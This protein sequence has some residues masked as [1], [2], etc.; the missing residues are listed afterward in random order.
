MYLHKNYFNDKMTDSY[1]LIISQKAK[2]KKVKEGKIGWDS[3]PSNQIYQ[4]EEKGQ[5]QGQGERQ[6]KRERK[7]GREEEGQRE[8]EK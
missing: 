6:R 8:K 5:G 4:T 7:E 1:K 2:R 3:A